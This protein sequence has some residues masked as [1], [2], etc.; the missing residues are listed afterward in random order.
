MNDNVL[1]IKVDIDKNNNNLI[2]WETK[3]TP[4]QAN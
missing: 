1:T 3:E 4:T 2:Y